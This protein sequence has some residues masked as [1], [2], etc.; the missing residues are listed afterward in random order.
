M[1]D[2]QCEVLVVGAGP[3][4]SAAAHRAAV[5]GRDVLLLDM[6]DFPRDKTCGDGLTPRAVHALEALGAGDLVA[7][8]AGRPEIRGLKLH[9]FGGSVTAP[10]P[11][12]PEVPARGTAVARTDL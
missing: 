8:A 5:A 6:Q 9:G 7:P 4:G 11:D 1:N 3:A 10:W 2:I 12:H